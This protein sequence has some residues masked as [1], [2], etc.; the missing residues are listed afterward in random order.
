L[1]RRRTTAA[2]AARPLRRPGCGQGR[3]SVRLA[4]RTRCRYRVGAVR[5]RS[6]PL[7]VTSLPA[8]RH[9]SLAE[10]P[11]PWPP[12]RPAIGHTPCMGP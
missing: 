6:H 10:S 1:P 9:P 5:R 3:R 2:G 7:S 11:V 4:D 12:S 8:R